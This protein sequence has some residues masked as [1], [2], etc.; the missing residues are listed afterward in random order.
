MYLQKGAVR[1]TPEVMLWALK[2]VDLGSSIHIDGIIL[3]V[4][5]RR[6]RSYGRERGDL[7]ARRTVFTE[8]DLLVAL[9]YVDEYHLLCLSNSS[10]FGWHCFNMTLHDLMGPT[11]TIPLPV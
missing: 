5:S 7:R 8:V 1:A 4:L 2:I 11:V 10:C 6:T 9:K 3:H